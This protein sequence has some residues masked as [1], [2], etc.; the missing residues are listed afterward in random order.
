ME[1]RF[2]NR[3]FISALAVIAALGT[4]AGSSAA[5]G[6]RSPAGQQI[7]RGGTFTIV[8][9]GLTWS[10]LDPEQSSNVAQLF[11]FRPMFDSLFVYNSQDFASLY[12]T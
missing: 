1:K 7:K 3:L 12:T 6:A 9:N 2:R 11:T 5:F 4:F 10:S 8:D